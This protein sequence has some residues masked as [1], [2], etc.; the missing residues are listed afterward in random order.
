MS[1]STS[2]EDVSN[3]IRGYKSTL[4]NP[5]VSDEAKQNAEKMINQLEG[6]GMP[7]DAGEGNKDPSRVVGGLKAA[8][9]NPN[10]S[11][12]GKEAAQQKLD[13]M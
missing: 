5:N 10:V 12:E 7:E 9:N 6:K 4:S 3:Q 8:I 2:P 11:E 1:T 13:N